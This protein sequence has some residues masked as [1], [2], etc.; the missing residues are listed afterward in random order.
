LY[1][2]SAVRMEGLLH[3]NT[4]DGDRVA[5]CVSRRRS[6]CTQYFATKPKNICLTN[7]ARLAHDSCNNKINSH[8]LVQQDALD[9]GKRRILPCN[10]PW[11]HRGGI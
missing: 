6:E 10:T 2:A 8:S 1:I 3:G 5:E 4:S 7:E 9:V 11:R